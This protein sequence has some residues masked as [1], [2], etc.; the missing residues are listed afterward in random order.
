MHQ[1]AHD[2]RIAAQQARRKQHDAYNEARKGMNV[3]GTAE[4][5][6]KLAGLL[7][8]K[9]PAKTRY[10]KE[11][12]RIKKFGGG[13]LEYAQGG[14]PSRGGSPAPGM[15]GRP[16]MGRGYGGGRGMQGYGNDMLYPGQFPPGTG[17]PSVPAPVTGGGYP[18][19]PQTGGGY[20]LPKGLFTGNFTPSN[21][22]YYN[23][24]YVPPPQTGGFLPQYN[25]QQPQAFKRGGNVKKGKTNINIIIASGKQ[26]GEPEMPAPV[27]PP[28]GAMPPPNM[29]PG[30]PPGGAPPMPPMPPM[31]GPPG[32][33]PGMPPMPRKA[34][35]RITK[36]AH[37]Y[38]DMQAGA[39]SG[40]GRLQK[41]EIAAYQREGRKHGGKAYHSFKDLTAGAG[42]GEGRLQKTDIA[43]YK[44][45]AKP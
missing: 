10:A 19:V 44:R 32:M 23:S 3:P 41:S 42:S 4:N 28:P 38:K 34:G 12:G 26:K 21:Q 20:P 43:A 45:S 18:P 36:T 13:A 1:K 14:M 39:G 9:G 7:K 16:Q 31:G 25:P 27:P 8:D 22:E 24:N 37:S 11:G 2:A 6:A 35:G 30:P 29:P 17:G 5:A 33:P 40:E 15:M